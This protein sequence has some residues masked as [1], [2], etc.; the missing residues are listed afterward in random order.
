MNSIKRI[1]AQEQRY[2]RDHD[3]YMR[4]RE[5]RL[6][7]RYDAYHAD[8]DASRSYYRDYRIKRIMDEIQ[9]I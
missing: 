5:A 2:K 1:L 8:I 6:R 3:R 7:K 9:R 4:Q